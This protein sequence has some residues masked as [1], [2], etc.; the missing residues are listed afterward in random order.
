MIIFLTMFFPGANVLGLLAVFAG[1]MITARAVM[2]SDDEAIKVAG[3]SGAHGYGVPKITHD[4]YVS[5][6][7]VRNLIRQSRNARWGLWLIAFGTA[8]QILGAVPSFFVR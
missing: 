6:P 5:Q 3:Q 8:L 2:V 7:A 1:A 4:Q